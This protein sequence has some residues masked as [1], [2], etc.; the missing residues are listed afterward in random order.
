[1]RAVGTFRPSVDRVLS[2]GIHLLGGDGPIM[3]AKDEQTAKAVELLAGL[4][5]GE[6]REMSIDALR[7]WHR[8]RTSALTFDTRTDLAPNLVA[9]IC[10]RKEIASIP[11]A[12]SYSEAFMHGLNHPGMTSLVEFLHWFTRA[13]SPFRFR[14]RRPRSA[15]A[16]SAKSAVSGSNAGG[17]MNRAWSHGK[18]ISVTV[19][20]P[21][22]SFPR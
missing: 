20:S 18:S 19:S 14:Q 17:A 15:T 10:V 16:S 7:A 5:D 22:S 4:S 1:M 3:K 11:Q 13:A 9:R 2:T 21:T 6:V 8:T 12:A